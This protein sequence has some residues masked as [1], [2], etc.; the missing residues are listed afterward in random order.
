[1]A[2]ILQHLQEQW[3]QA[4][5]I[6]STSLL[7]IKNG[8]LEHV[9][10]PYVALREPGFYNITRVW[11]YLLFL[12][13]TIPHFTQ[14]GENPHEYPAEFIPMVYFLS[15]YKISAHL[16][17]VSMLPLIASA[18]TNEIDRMRLSS[19][20]VFRNIR[21]AFDQKNFAGIF[22]PHFIP[23]F[24]AL[25][26]CGILCLDI[27]FNWGGWR[28][29]YHQQGLSMIHERAYTA[30]LMTICTSVILERANS[31]I[32]N[33]YTLCELTLFSPK[34]LAPTYTKEQLDKVDKPEL[35]CPLLGAYPDDEDAVV[36]SAKWST[37]QIY[38]REVL[39]TWIKYKGNRSTKKVS[40]PLTHDQ[41]DQIG[42]A[43]IFPA[44]KALLE[45]LRAARAEAANEGQIIAAHTLK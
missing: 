27:T 8:C 40:H 37:T 7:A 31:M 43:N 15:L 32:K 10:I 12:S 45:K 29:E 25:L 18:I 6:T 17:L 28:T 1:M 21:R 2:A 24:S 13:G 33:A 30:I 20:V 38:S 26:I 23:F 39:E 3:R 44:P 16:C 42:L 11:T 5:I 36:I 19:L 4:K 35:Q 22:T 41:N 9:R 34:P 14:Y